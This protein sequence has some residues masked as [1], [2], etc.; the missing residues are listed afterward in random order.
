MKSVMNGSKKKSAALWAMIALNALLVAALISR[1]TPENKAMAAGARVGDVLA[2]P[3][4]LPGF[5]NGVVFLVDTTNQQLTVIS[6]DT[7]NRGNSDIQSMRPLDLAKL[8]NSAGGVRG[9]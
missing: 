5:S 9:K 4:Q 3:G 1:H 2:V 6:V 8:M 7:A